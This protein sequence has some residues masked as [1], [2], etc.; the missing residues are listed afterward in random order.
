MNELLEVE[1]DFKV[2]IEQAKIYFWEYIIA[3]KEMKPFH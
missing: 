1:K 3:T 2:V